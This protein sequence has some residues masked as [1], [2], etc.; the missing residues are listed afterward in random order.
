MMRKSGNFAVS[1][2]ALAAALLSFEASAADPGATVFA[3]AHGAVIDSAAARAYVATATAGLQSRALEDGARNWRSAHAGVPLALLAHEVLLVQGAPPA[4]GIARLLLL[5]ADTGTLQRTVD[6]T[7][8]EAVR[9]DFQAQPQRRFIMAAVPGASAGQVRLAWEFTERPLQGAWMATGEGETVG[10]DVIAERGLFDL[11]PATG[12]LSTGSGEPER[13]TPLVPP[14][15]RIATLGQRTQFQSADAAHAEVS[16]AVE[17]PQFGTVWNWELHDL[18]DGDRLGTVQLPVSYAPFQMHGG[19]LLVQL[20]PMAW[21]ATDA[22]F[23][24]RERRLTVLTLADGTE[25]WSVDLLDPEFRGV[26]P[27]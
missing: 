20:P 10:V 1:A 19:S 27:P 7:L 12:E 18:A 13:F 8:P 17:H 15:R 14:A 6:V 26:L 16:A 4:P 23:E 5:D 2:V 3:L 9:A 25:R 22:G 21:R 11:D 24:V